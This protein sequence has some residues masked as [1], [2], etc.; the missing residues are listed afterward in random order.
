MSRKRKNQCDNDI[1]NKNTEPEDLYEIFKTDDNNEIIENL[2][3]MVNK[4]IDN[5]CNKKCTNKIL[6]AS[7]II[8]LIF[9][10]NSF[11]TPSLRVIVILS[12]SH[13]PL[14]ISIKYNNTN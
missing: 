10:L 2:F 5:Y 3:E 12:I 11:W 8:Y 1:I 13:D 4:E 7:G 14:S 9:F 6:I